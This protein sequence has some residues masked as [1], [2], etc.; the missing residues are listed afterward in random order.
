MA[1]FRSL[2]RERHLQNTLDQHG[3][4]GETIDR[5]LKDGLSDRELLAVIK[6]VVE[7]FGGDYAFDPEAVDAGDPSLLDEVFDQI[8]EG[9]GTNGDNQ[10]LADW[11]LFEDG[12]PPT[13]KQTDD[14]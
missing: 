2:L 11:S 10:D 9:A 3:F 5:L 7:E 4:A 6:L 1:V 8:A 14:D 13:P 12:D